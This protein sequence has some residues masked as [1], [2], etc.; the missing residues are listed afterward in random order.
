MD[1]GMLSPEINSGR[2]Y[3]GPGSAPMI[4]AAAA[5]DDL[6]AGLQAG[7]ASY[8]SAISGLTAE[9]QGPSSAAMAAAA[10]PYAAW[11]RATAA[12]A[13]QTANQARA[14]A[15]AYETAF[16][17]TVPPP[18]VAANRSLL[19]SL[20]ATNILGQNTAAIGATEAHYA[21][22]WAQDAAAMY[23][24][25]G[26]S[27]SA[28][29]LTPFEAPPQTTNPTVQAA[30][31]A[32]ATGTSAQALPQ[33]TNLTSGI[34]QTLQTLAPVS[35]AAPAATAD[36]PSATSLLQ[37]LSYGI[38]GFNPIRLYDP[39]GAFY[40]E[41]VQ[42]FLAPFNNYNMQVAYAGALERAGLTA[43]VRPATGVPGG[44]VSA[45]MGRAGLVG[46]LSV[47]QGWASAAPAIR[48][49]AVVL[50]A[51]NIGAVP[52]ALAGDGEGSVFSNM[53]LSGLAGRAVA[54]NGETVARSVS[55]SAVPGAATTATIIVIP[56]D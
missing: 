41:G 9:W 54:G 56:E 35:S 27:A 3:A 17:A 37:L 23:G 47:P 30:T 26:S 19:M 42:S 43:G 52:A 29:Q 22:M 1:F 25:A 8:S 20:I 13:E 24:Y 40:D 46:T 33:L 16:A 5:W 45:G 50:P 44:A 15:A 18:I 12:Q 21:E 4:A 34:S 14:A 6:A 10:A 36:P 2:M 55:G 32:P 51:T 39:F 38:G 7:A 53:A 48:P 31:S 28:S 49:V 11:M